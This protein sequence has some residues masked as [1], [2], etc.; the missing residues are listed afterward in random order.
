[1]RIL[2]IKPKD[3]SYNHQKGLF[4]RPIS[5][6]PLTL[7]L[8][9]SLV[10]KEIN[11]EI[12]ILDEVVD[13]TPIDY[14]VDIMGISVLTATANRAY[15]ITK[16]ARG[17]GVYVILGGIHVSLMP[18]ESLQYADSI[19][20]GQAELSW[21]QFLKDYTEGRPNKIYKEDNPVNLSN[22]PFPR[23]DL[24]LKSK[25]LPIPTIQAS[26]GCSNNCKFCAISYN[27]QSRKL[28]RPI[29]D[30]LNEIK[31]L[32]TKKLLFL[33]PNF[34]IDKNY[35]AELM[36][37]LI[38][39]K[40]KWGCLTTVDVAEDSEQ[41]DLMKKS[42]CVGVLIGFESIC[43]NTLIS[44]NKKFN[45]PDRYK[46]II[47]SFHN[48]GLAVLG[49]FVF[50][51]DTDN[52]DVF[53]ETVDFVNSSGIDLPRFSV[54]T[55]FPGTPIFNELEEQKRIIIKNWGYYDFQ[56][57]VYKPKLMTEQELQ[58]GLIWSWRETYKIK[59]TIKRVSKINKFTMLGLLA[60]F[61]FRKYGYK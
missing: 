5:Y 21:P 12:K 20:I 27:L 46:T 11:A 56:H 41:M 16:K 22:L 8:L 44:I 28:Q 33:D 34:N 25:Y 30:V 35:S 42:G 58:Q 32:T 47:D 50:G 2:L 14:T 39:L 36:K 10:P 19:I 43:Q 61:S 4:S 38:P 26:R 24:L 29:D 9:A 45:N 6:A 53:A 51:F 23:R 3:I 13:D 57:V 55:P 49:C 17:K 54:L 37:K 48:Y 60:N 7:T 59:N 15:E 1:M 18:D 31:S 52:K 40:I